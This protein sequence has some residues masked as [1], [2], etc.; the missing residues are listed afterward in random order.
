MSKQNR[1][2]SPPDLTTVTVY[3]VIMGLAPL[4][5]ECFFLYYQ[6]RNWT[7]RDRKPVRNWKVLAFNW[8]RSFEKARPLM[9]RS[10]RCY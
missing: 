9:K 5:A 1:Q 10:I 6:K 7:L 8:V 3:F 4:H 2:Q